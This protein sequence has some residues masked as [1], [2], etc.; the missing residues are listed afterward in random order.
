MSQ[1]T[2]TA[3]ASPFI[4]MDR[5]AWSRLRDRHHIPLTEAD[6]ERISGVGAE[7]N[8]REVEDVYLP[9][10]GCSASTSTPPRDCT[11][12]PASS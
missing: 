3:Y 7:I 8:L 1:A 12:S 4:E 5:A 2:S 11:R 10:P 6:L 9:C